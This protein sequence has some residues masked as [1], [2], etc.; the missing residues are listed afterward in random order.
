MFSQS[1]L[2]EIK[3]LKPY[4]VSAVL[5]IF[6]SY[7]IYLFC[8]DNTV[9]TLGD[10]DGFF[11]YL[12]AIFFLMAV[13]FLI[14]TFRR[15]KN[16]F[17]IGLA[18]ILFMGAGEEISWGQRLF[19]FGT[20][21][22]MLKVNVQHE[23]NIHNLEVFNDQS[24]KGV[25]KTGLQR[26][27]EINILYRIFSVVFLICIPLFFY[28]IKLRLITDKKIR[29]PVAPITIGIFF[30]ISWVIFYSLKYSVLPRGKDRWYYS[31]AGEIFEFLAAYIYF[32]TAL[33]FYKRKDDAYLGKDIK[34]ILR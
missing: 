7:S 22:S 8:D 4:I 18:L 23:F 2:K 30:F 20:P 12:T 29:M 6:L 5:V 17:L 3:Y 10:E 21:K 32:L 34:N 14:L 33:F 24:L 13:V 11:E 15:T 9:I 16:I 19:N 27:L 31:T 25:K 26:L 28:H 1:Y